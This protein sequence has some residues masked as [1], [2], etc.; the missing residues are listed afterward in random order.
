[1]NTC[2]KCLKAFD[3]WVDYHEHLSLINCVTLEATTS[4]PK[5]ITPIES[6]EEALLAKSIYKVVSNWRPKKDTRGN[7][8]YEGPMDTKKKAEIVARVERRLGSLIVG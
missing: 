1:M 2:T 3:H 6:F 5:L 7:P 8:I 4:M